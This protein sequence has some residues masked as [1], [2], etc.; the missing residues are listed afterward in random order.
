MASG[1]PSRQSMQQKT[2]T[3]VTFLS[4]VFGNL[5][6][7]NN[8]QV[9]TKTNW[10]RQKL[11]CLSSIGVWRAIPLNLALYISA[12][13]TSTSTSLVSSDWQWAR[14]NSVVREVIKSILHGGPIELFLVPASAP[15]LVQ[16]RLWY[17]LSCLWDDAFKRTLAA[18]YIIS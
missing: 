10:N 16:Q 17:V 3:K 6:M 7:M 1:R 11:K 13:I 18:N 5:S 9:S 12:R 4:R 8:R 14:C 15:W 2:M